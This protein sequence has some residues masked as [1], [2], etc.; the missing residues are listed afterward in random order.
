[1]TAL[2]LEGIRLR[3]GGVTALDGLGFT[4]EPGTVHALIGPNGAGKSSCFNVISGHYRPEAGTVAF[5]DDDLTHLPPH[6]IARRGVGRAFQNIAL[7]AHETVL[8]NLMVARHR[9]TRSGFVATALGLSRVRRE[10]RLHQA[11]VTEIAEFAGLGGK[12]DTLAGALAYGDRKRVEL[13]RALASEPG[14]VLLDEPAAG[15]PSHEKWDIAHLIV[16]VRDALGISVLLV[17]HDM[18]MV[19]AIA[20]RVTVLDFGRR[21]AGGTP[22]EVQN[23][24]EVIA[25]YLGSSHPEAGAVTVS[26]AR[27]ETS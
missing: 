3:F 19:M 22:A 26:P 14:I 7:S 8:D 21:I 24:P 1:M 25:A 9:L 13:A 23:S 15:M 16:S 20:D 17:E 10:E 6:E 5:G 18:P 12:L 27:E 11:R 2:R 4:V